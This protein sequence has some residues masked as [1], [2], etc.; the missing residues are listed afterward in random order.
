MLIC[1]FASTGLAI[2]CW[3]CEFSSDPSIE[4]LKKPPTNSNVKNYS[5]PTGYTVKTCPSSVGACQK[6]HV[7]MNLG[8]LNIDITSRG[9][10]TP[11]LDQM[12]GRCLKMDVQGT[13]TEQCYCSGNK[14]NSAMFSAKASFSAVVIPT[15][16]AMIS[17]QI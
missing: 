10:A 8:G 12:A 14:C 1:A 3:N 15:I 5:L 4:C 6:G 17:N 2:E 7:K 9:C 13:N 16:L 11:G